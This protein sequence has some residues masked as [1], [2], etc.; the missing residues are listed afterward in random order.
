MGSRGP[1]LP[2]IG[3]GLALIISAV[4]LTRLEAGTSTLSLVI[5]YLLFG[6]GFGL[7]NAPITNT[8]MAGMP[9]AQAGVAAA[10][11]ST[12]RQVGSSLGVA[13]I[14]SVVVTALAGPL[15]DRVRPASH[16][17]WWVTVG[18][19]A[20]VLL[21]GLVTTGAW[22]RR[23]AER[24]ATK[25]AP[26]SRHG[27]AAGRCQPARRM[28]TA[29][30]Q[31]RRGKLAEAPQLHFPGRARGRYYSAVASDMDMMAKAAPWSSAR[32]AIRP[33]GVSHGGASTWPPSLVAISTA[34][35]A[36]STAK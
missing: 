35:S 5:S 3:A 16:V 9:Q 18:C 12:S 6:L 31:R 25:F 34:P 19:G 7:V 10:V 22:A 30:P 20:L 26:A 8:A 17:G 32:I 4:S 23:T 13:V 14:G 1:R 36:L 15:Q 27:P 2:L 33:Y 28:P 11:A 24:V 21:L 29:R